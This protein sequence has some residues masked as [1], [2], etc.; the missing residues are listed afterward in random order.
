MRTIKVKVMKFT[1]LEGKARETARKV[2][3]DL[4]SDEY[5]ESIFK[6]AAEDVEG[7]AR[8]LGL[9]GLKLDSS[10][11]CMNF[12]IDD[13]PYGDASEGDDIEFDINSHVRGLLRYGNLI[14]VSINGLVEACKEFAKQSNNRDSYEC[15]KDNARLAVIR[16]L[17]KVYYDCVA[18]DEEYMSTDMSINLFADANGMVFDENGKDATR[19]L[20]RH[21]LNI[22]D[23]LLGEKV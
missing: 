15:E 21:I 19:L 1:E 4:Y 3:R 23:T 11:I 7:Y 12:D 16:E 10:K 8:D 14:P 18:M 5:K 13:R 9:T 22:R 6:Y 2:V 20:E 17:A